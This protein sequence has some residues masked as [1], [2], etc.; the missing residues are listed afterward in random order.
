MS[1]H[2]RNLHAQRVC[3]VPIDN[4]RVVWLLSSL[5]EGLLPELSLWS[6]NVQQAPRRNSIRVDLRT[7]HMQIAGCSVHQDYFHREPQWARFREEL[8]TYLDF[9]ADT[10]EFFADWCAEPPDK[11]AFDY[12]SFSHKI[13]QKY[14]SALDRFPLT[15]AL[16]GYL[17][18]AIKIREA[19]YFSQLNSMLVEDFGQ[20]IQIVTELFLASPKTFEPWGLPDK[21]DGNF[22]DKLTNLEGLAD[23]P[24]DSAVKGTVILY[25]DAPFRQQV[26]M[27]VSRVDS[28]EDVF[29]SWSE[30]MNIERPPVGDK[31]ADKVKE[32][33]I[34]PGGPSGLVPTAEELKYI[35]ARIDHGKALHWGELQR[36]AVKRL[37]DLPPFRSFK[38]EGDVGDTIRVT[39]KYDGTH[40]SASNVKLRTKSRFSKSLLVG[41]Q[42]KQWLDRQGATLSALSSDT[43]RP[44]FAKGVDVEMVLTRD[45]VCYWNGTAHAM[46]E[47][48]WAKP[49]GFKWPDSDKDHAG[50]MHVMTTIDQT[51]TLAEKQELVLKYIRKGR[52]IRDWGLCDW[53]QAASSPE[54][55]G[56]REVKAVFPKKFDLSKDSMA[57]FPLCL[58]HYP[59][60]TT[61]AF[62]SEIPKALA[63]LR[64]SKRAFSLLQ[65]PS[66]SKK[67]DAYLYARSP[68]KPKRRTSRAPSL[69]VAVSSPPTPRKPPS[70]PKKASKTPEE[71][72]AERVEMENVELLQKLKQKRMKAAETPVE[73]IRYFRMK[74]RAKKGELSGFSHPRSITEEEYLAF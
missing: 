8:T 33:Q 66:V 14:A 23:I 9:H 61:V 65:T 68:K 25:R 44:R 72:E 2:Q 62:K 50:M 28:A 35:R 43:L 5:A 45:L 20:F 18:R 69:T 1:Q 58:G 54:G 3:S 56:L 70:V 67:S 55:I 19:Q 26:A 47:N 13:E 48:V 63:L 37:D 51:A 22:M 12:S 60:A 41:P 39:L 38:P 57:I 46:E 21:A 11:H 31:P 15:K 34:K 32:R 74:C 64:P 52:D 71:L 59:L 27:F 42:L 49:L 73:D 30:Q 29:L 40:S 53:Q 17:R 36:K 7:T 6:G 16:M 10:F 24:C 4:M